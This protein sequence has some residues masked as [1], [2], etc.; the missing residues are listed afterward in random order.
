MNNTTWI[1][2]SRKN[3]QNILDE[4]REFYK[5]NDLQINNNK[6]ILIVINGKK[7]KSKLVQAGLNKE[8]VIALNNKKTAKFL[9]I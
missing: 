2:K 5:A 3:L 4:A 7:G 6:L 1:V 8:S 9:K